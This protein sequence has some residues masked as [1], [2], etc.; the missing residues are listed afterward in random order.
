MH[1]TCRVREELFGNDT[2]PYMVTRKHL[3]REIKCVSNYGYPSR[4]VDYSATV[5]SAMELHPRKVELK[6]LIYK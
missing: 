6:N 5:N 3:K 2:S 1:R 4:S